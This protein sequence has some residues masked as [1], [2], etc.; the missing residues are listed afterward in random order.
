ME[1]ALPQIEELLL[2]EKC[3]YSRTDDPGDEIETGIVSAIHSVNR[4]ENGTNTSS[5]V[6]SSSDSDAGRRSLREA[7][8]ESYEATSIRDGATMNSSPIE[9]IVDVS[10][11]ALTEAH[12]KDLI[13]LSPEMVNLA[14][15]KDESVDSPRAFKATK[16]DRGSSAI[17]PIR[18]SPSV[19]AASDESQPFS[20]IGCEQLLEETSEKSILAIS[21]DPCAASSTL[22]HNNSPMDPPSVERQLICIGRKCPREVRD[23]RS[24]IMQIMG[25]PETSQQVEP[26]ANEEN[27][28]IDSFEFNSS[29]SRGEVFLAGDDTLDESPRRVSG[30]LV[31]TCGPSLYHGPAGNE[32]VEPQ[33]LISTQMAKNE[34]SITDDC[35]PGT[36]ADDADIKEMETKKTSEAN[37]EQIEGPGR[38]TRSATR[39]SDDTKMLKDFVNRVQARKAAKDVPIP[40]YVAAPMASPRRSPRKALAEVSKNSPSPHKPNDL[41]NRPGTPPGNRKLEIIDSDDLDEIAAEQT[42]CRRSARTRFFAPSTTA[43][44]APSFIPVRRVDGEAIVLLQKS[45][46]QELATITRTNTKQNKGES[47]PPKMTLRT[48]AADASE[49]NIERPGGPGEARA[50]GW[51]ETLVYYQNRSEWKAGKTEKRRTVGRTRNVG[52]TNNNGTPARTKLV[53]E[54]DHSHGASAVGGRSKSKSKSKSKGKS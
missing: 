43:A 37:Q 46:A 31:E 33:S 5:A 25:G 41:A 9:D 13:A 17:T 7:T 4:D 53:R 38:R 18:L 22:G 44:G 54:T 34:G 49:E 51:D 8:T 1:E 28:L 42:T 15:P 36:T 19:E 40:V 47:K 21:A 14:S 50:V 24:S 12:D 3:D 26:V 29:A 20:I 23:R 16:S 2:P 30:F 10:P 11:A 35:N 32:T 48:L 39:F 45:Q 6:A 52:A 27:S